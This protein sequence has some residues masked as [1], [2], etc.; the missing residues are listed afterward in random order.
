MNDRVNAFEE[1]QPEGELDRVRLQCHQALKPDLSPEALKAAQDCLL[2]NYPQYADDLSIIFQN[3]GA[4]GAWQPRPAVP[5]SACRA[6]R[7]SASRSKA[8]WATFTV[9]GTWS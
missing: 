3:D 7:S 6:T 1:S 5:K 8:A 9:P 2:A 4:G